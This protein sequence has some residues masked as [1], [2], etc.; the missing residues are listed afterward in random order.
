MKID[1]AVIGPI[2][3]AAAANVD[4]DPSGVSPANLI[5]AQRDYLGAH[6]SEQIDIKG[7]F[8]SEWEKG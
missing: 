4:N 3:E 8:Y 5:Q 2:F 1:R 7:T 6:T